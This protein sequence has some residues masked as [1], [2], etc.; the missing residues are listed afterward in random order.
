MAQDLD[1][2]APHWGEAP[3]GKHAAGGSKYVRYTYGKSNSGKKIK[4]AHYSDGTKEIRVFDN[5]DGDHT[6]YKR[7]SKGNISKSYHYGENGIK[8]AIEDSTSKR[9]IPKVDG[10]DTSVKPKLSPEEA[11]KRGIPRVTG[12]KVKNTPKPAGMSKVADGGSGGGGNTTSGK[13][14]TGGSEFFKNLGKFASLEQL[15]EAPREAMNYINSKRAEKGL[16]PV[17]LSTDDSSENIRRVT[18]KNASEID[19]AS[20]GTGEDSEPTSEFGF[21]ESMVN[22]GQRWIKEAKKDEKTGKYTIT[23]TPDKS[24]KDN[25]AVQNGILRNEAAV[26]QGLQES[27]KKQKASTSTTSTAKVSPKGGIYYTGGDRSKSKSGVLWSDADSKYTDSVRNSAD[28]KRSRAD[29]DR[30]EYSNL[31]DAQKDQRAAADI[32]AWNKGYRPSQT[33]VSQKTG[34]VYNASAKETT[35]TSTPSTTTTARQYKNANGDTIVV[36][37]GSKTGVGINT[38]IYRTPQEWEEIRKNNGSGYGPQ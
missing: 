13:S 15:N 27:E 7:D 32:K 29:Y 6:L 22:R 16:N 25:T 10:V 8:K 4:Y 11:A 34:T 20:G 33:K 14:V 26:E 31:T 28:F 9:G 3:T 35:T 19:K 30:P 5:A 37:A 38:S 12:E 23:P 18:K 36:P 1:F 17:E 24:K 21:T 2:D